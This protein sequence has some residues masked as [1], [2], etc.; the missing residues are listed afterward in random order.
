[1]TVIKGKAMTPELSTNDYRGNK[2]LRGEPR[3]RGDVTAPR[4]STERVWAELAKASFAIIS[5]ATPTGAPRSSG[6][7]YGV[8]GRHLYVA[9]APHSWKARQIANGQ[10]VAVTVPVRRGGLLSLLMSIP[11]ATISFRARAIVHPA[12]SFE[13]GS[14]SKKL[15]SLLPKGRRAG[16]VLELV[17]EGSFLTY[18]I[19]VSLK[20]M[21]DP[22][23]ALAH[24]PIG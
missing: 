6:V 1:M 20:E 24:V 21:I 17:P 4:A 8:G 16:V 2:A 15:E 14:V 9:V 12:G 13:V 11:P 5:Y 18:G 23:A 10:Q 22:V 19:G 7:V 3:E